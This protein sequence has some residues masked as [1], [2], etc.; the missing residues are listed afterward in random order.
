MVPS[1]CPCPCH[2]RFYRDY[3]NVHQISNFATPLGHPTGVIKPGRVREAAGAERGFLPALP[4][5]CAHAVELQLHSTRLAGV[6]AADCVGAGRDRGHPSL[7]PTRLV[8]T[9]CVRNIHRCGLFRR[10][11]FTLAANTLPQAPSC[12]SGA[13]QA[14][15]KATDES[16]RAHGAEVHRRHCAPR[17]NCLVSFV[18][19]RSCPGDSSQARARHPL[20]W[21]LL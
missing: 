11:L 4:R 14:V 18:H 8:R 2:V 10:H 7:R 17:V 20:R 9:G 6:A 16:F 21:A 3:R 1:P 13:R 19:R 5:A 15:Y 12:L